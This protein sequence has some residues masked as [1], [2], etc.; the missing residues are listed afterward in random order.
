VINILRA[1]YGK[2]L[3]VGNSVDKCKTDN[4][5]KYTYNYLHILASCVFLSG[6][7]TIRIHGH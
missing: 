5:Y 7:C 6:V 1:T 4:V 2:C 3:Y